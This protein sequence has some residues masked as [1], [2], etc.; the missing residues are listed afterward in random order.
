MPKSKAPVRAK[1]SDA[2]FVAVIAKLIKHDST[3]RKV[4]DP[5]T[6]AQRLVRESK[7]R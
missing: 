2:P 4:F 5:I 7:R 6:R 1:R 3:G